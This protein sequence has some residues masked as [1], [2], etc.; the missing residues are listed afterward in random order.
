M[1]KG[2][3][4]EFKKKIALLHLREGRTIQSLHVEYGIAKSTI[5]VWCDNYQQECQA[6]AEENPDA[7]NEYT[8]MKENADLRKKLAE[9][10][11]EN[12]F[13]KK[14]AAFFAKELD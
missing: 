9:V 5:N 6:K 12:L 8:L 4:K 10:E 1:S 13:L 7:V 11:K 14:A 2:Y 3:D